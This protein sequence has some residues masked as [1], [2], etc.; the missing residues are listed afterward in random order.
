M[1]RRELREHCFKMLFSANFYDAEEAERQLTIIL[2]LPKRMRRM[3]RDTRRCSIRS[4]WRKRTGSIS[5][6]G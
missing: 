4:P 5:R 6:T 1:T 2:T 3:R